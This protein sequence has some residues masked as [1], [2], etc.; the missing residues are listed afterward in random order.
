MKKEKKYYKVWDLD[1]EE[2]WKPT[3]GRK[4]TADIWTHPTFVKQTIENQN[5]G[6]NSGYVPTNYEIVEF[7]LK[8]TN[9]D[10]IVHSTPRCNE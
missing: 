8:E 3:Q 1:K 4:R 10:R 6:W 7:E 2:W 9:S 5:Y